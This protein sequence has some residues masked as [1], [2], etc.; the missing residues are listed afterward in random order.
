M[1]RTHVSLDEE[2]KKIKSEGFVREEPSNGL[3]RPPKSYTC[4]FCKGIYRSAQ[5]LGGHMN[6][7]RW[8]RARLKQLSSWIVEHHPPP[9]NPNPK[10]DV[11]SSSQGSQSQS[12]LNPTLL[13]PAPPSSPSVNKPF[14]CA[15]P[16]SLSSDL[17]YKERKKSVDISANDGLP[18]GFPRPESEDARK[19]RSRR[20]TGVAGVEE[21]AKAILDKDEIIE[22]HGDLSKLELEIGL[23]KDPSCSLDL[24][25]RVGIL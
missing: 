16:P 3:L 17:D 23:I 1:D 25:L 18:S 15:S 4:R 6:V 8:E 12:Q 19:K 22:V 13:P 20:S 21:E 14:S 7:H 24:E 9:P 2:G 11:A 10:I 5:A